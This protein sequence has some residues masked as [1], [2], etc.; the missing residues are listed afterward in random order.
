MDRGGVTLTLFGD[1][2]YRF[3]NYSPQPSF[4]AMEIVPLVLLSPNK[5][6]PLY[7]EALS[8]RHILMNV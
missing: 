2:W 8:T 4:W 5:Q 3:G 7:M 6:S 1:F